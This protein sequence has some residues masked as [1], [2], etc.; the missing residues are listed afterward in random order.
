MFGSFGG[1]EARKYEDKR[2]LSQPRVKGMRD[3]L[4]LGPAFGGIRSGADMSDGFLDR[5][6]VPANTIGT[7]ELASSS[8]SDVDRA[9]GPDHIKSSSI[10][11]RHLTS[12]S[13]M[14]TNIFSVSP[15]KFTRNLLTPDYGALTVTDP[16]IS[17][18][19]PDKLTRL[20]AT[21]DYANVSVTD[22]KIASVSPDK[23]SRLLVAG[24]LG[25]ASVTPAKLDR[26]YA[27]SSVLGATTSSTL[28]AG[29]AGWVYSTV[30]N[31]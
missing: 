9:V 4:N 28:P 31:P 23:L 20:L 16:K 17:A 3:A 7:V 14:D 25:S 21:T 18:V 24:D 27:Q 1:R 2:S 8:S 30:A 26:A 29:A 12:L 13:V 10:A 6:H 11:N 15:D 5:R 19:S 22:A